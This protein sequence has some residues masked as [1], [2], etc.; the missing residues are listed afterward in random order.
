VA[1][2]DNALIVDLLVKSK[3]PLINIGDTWHKKKKVGTRENI[4]S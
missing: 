2:G 4:I 3:K 1:F